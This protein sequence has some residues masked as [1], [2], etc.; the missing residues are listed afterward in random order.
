MHWSLRTKFPVVISPRIVFSSHSIRKIFAAQWFRL[1]DIISD[2][3]DDRTPRTIVFIRQTVLPICIR[4]LKLLRPLNFEPENFNIL[5]AIKSIMADGELRNVLRRSCLNST[6][7]NSYRILYSDGYGYKIWNFLKFLN[8]HDEIKLN[9]VFYNH[10]DGDREK[11]QNVRVKTIFLLGRDPKKGTKK[12]KIEKENDIHG[13]ILMARADHT[14]FSGT[15][16]LFVRSMIT[17]L[18]MRSTLLKLTL[19]IR[20]KTWQ[21]K[22]TCS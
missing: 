19:T 20:F 14:S 7:W 1:N 10:F 15:I 4:S 21:S 2:F 22:N 17:S 9:T 11:T 5:I 13:D 8:R 16:V 6:F 12:S 3:L 18:K